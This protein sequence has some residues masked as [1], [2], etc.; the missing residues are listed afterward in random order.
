MTS[1]NSC[2]SQLFFK[3]IKQ[4]KAFIILHTIILFLCT[5][6]PAIMSKPIYYDLEVYQQVSISEYLLFDYVELLSFVAM[7]AA[8][9]A[10]F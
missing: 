2:N 9:F 3:T 4:N 5:L 8:F 1:R 7:V 6:V 10:A